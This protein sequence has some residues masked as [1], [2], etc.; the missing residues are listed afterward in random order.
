[1]VC[2]VPKV[3]GKKLAAAG[4][5]IRKHH[6]AVGKITKVKSPAKDKGHVLSQK[7]KPGRHLKKG[8]K[9]ALRVGK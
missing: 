5:A 2:V 1:V 7:P 6:C 4:T 8:A 3:K 9:V